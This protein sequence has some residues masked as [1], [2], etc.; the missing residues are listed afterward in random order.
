MKKEN[1]TTNNDELRE[2]YNLTEMKG[3]VRG[4]YAQRY[5]Q[6]SNV[7]I[8]APDVAEAFPNEESVNEALRMLINLA[9]SASRKAS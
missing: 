8:L 3:I 2:E 4:K 9:K 6:G 1:E 7:V 5:K